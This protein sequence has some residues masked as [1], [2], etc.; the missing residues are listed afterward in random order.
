MVTD[1]I[2]SAET[3]IDSPEADEPT[4]RGNEVQKN[5]EI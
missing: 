1:D 3:D 2:E 4:E 5:K